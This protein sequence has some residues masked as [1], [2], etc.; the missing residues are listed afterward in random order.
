MPKFPV[1]QKIPVFILGG[2]LSYLIECPFLCIFNLDTLKYLS[3]IFLFKNQR[4]K[5]FPK[6]RLAVVEKNMYFWTVRYFFESLE[7]GIIELK[8][9]NWWIF[10][11]LGVS[12]TNFLIAAA[13]LVSYNLFLWPKWS[14]EFVFFLY[15]QKLATK[16]PNFKTSPHNMSGISKNIY[17]WRQK[18]KRP[19]T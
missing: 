4:T 2:F 14:Y 3:Q 16:R 8:S 13:I 5:L 12:H 9:T 6:L 18:M 7:M 15:C 17:P 11:L 1:L 19:L 10:F